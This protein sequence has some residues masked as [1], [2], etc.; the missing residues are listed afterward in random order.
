MYPFTIRLKERVG[1]EVQP[2]RVKLDPGAKVT[3]TRRERRLF[4]SSI[5]PR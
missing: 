5:T 3:G 1:G 4:G 2:V